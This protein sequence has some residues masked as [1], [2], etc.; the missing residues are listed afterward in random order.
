MFIQKI[1]VQELQAFHPEVEK[2]KR[3]LI[4]EDE[5][6][7]SSLP[8]FSGRS[9]PLQDFDSDLN[10]LGLFECPQRYRGIH[11]NAQQCI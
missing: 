9:S 2:R 6:E 11:Q 5:E 8:D 3:N 4:S 10:P 1:E 7:R